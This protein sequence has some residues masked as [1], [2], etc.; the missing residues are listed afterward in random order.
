MCPPT[1]SHGYPGMCGDCPPQ[2]G[3]KIKQVRERGMQLLGTLRRSWRGKKSL[4]FH[5][6]SLKITIKVLPK[7]C[8]HWPGGSSIRSRRDAA[9]A[10]KLML[11]ASLPRS[12]GEE[13]VIES[14]KSQPIY[15]QRGEQADCWL[16][17]QV[18]GKA[19]TPQK[20]EKNC[21]QCVGGEGEVSQIM[22]LASVLWLRPSHV[23]TDWVWH[24]HGLL[25]S[26]IFKILTL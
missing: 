7:D 5:R 6:D 17:S 24:G 2:Q 1:P 26:N 15:T 10:L 23:P 13:A 25:S 20:C 18:A 16:W 14:N 4:Q 12:S 3:V 21:P 8:E 19:E 11:M 22:L 9:T